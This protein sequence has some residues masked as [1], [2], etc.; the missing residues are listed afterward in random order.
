MRQ[1]RNTLERFLVLGEELTESS[2]TPRTLS[3]SVDARLSY[4]VSREQAL[5]RFERAYV[6]ALLALHEGNVSKAAREAGLDRAYLHRLI[7]RA[8]ADET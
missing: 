7:R 3:E 1:L 2:P 8:K 5:G 6:T 4:A